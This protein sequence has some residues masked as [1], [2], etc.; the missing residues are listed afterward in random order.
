MTRVYSDSLK[1]IGLEK[2]VVEL[3]SELYSQEEFDAFISVLQWF[4]EANFA[5]QSLWKQTC[6]GDCCEHKR[7]GLDG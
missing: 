5:R 2:I 4:L 6:L 7:E 1:T 3:D